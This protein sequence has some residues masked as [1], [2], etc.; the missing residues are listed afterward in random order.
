MDVVQ[1][2]FQ[3]DGKVRINGE[4]VDTAG[5]RHLLKLREQRYL[6]PFP[7]EP[8]KCS[9]GRM[10]RDLAALEHHASMEKD[11]QEHI[12]QEE[13]AAGAKNKRQGGH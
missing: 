12:L 6:S 5:I 13:V 9:C 10:F 11:P 1:R 7:G 2:P 8:V 3:Y 4:V